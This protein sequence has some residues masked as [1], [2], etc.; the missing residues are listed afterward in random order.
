MLGGGQGIQAGRAGSADASASCS[1][2]L[3]G[4]VAEWLGAGLASD[5]RRGLERRACF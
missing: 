2:L 5:R 3:C 4:A 1:Q